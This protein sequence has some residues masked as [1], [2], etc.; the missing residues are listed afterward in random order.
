MGNTQTR[1]SR[2]PKKGQMSKTRAGRRD[3]TT[4]KSS[5]KFNRKG[6]RQSR[7]AKGVKRRPYSRRKRR[8]GYWDRG[9][10]K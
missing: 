6:H 5:T 4:K 7:S 3:F 10:E 8:G 9:E 2:N 1:K